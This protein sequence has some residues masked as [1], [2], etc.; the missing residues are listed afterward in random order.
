M[1]RSPRARAS[2][3]LYHVTARG[4]G[5]QLL[6]EDDADR[7]RFMELLR[8]A[9]A[10]HGIALLAW[11]LMGNHVHLLLEDPEFELSK[12]MQKLLSSYARYYNTRTGHVGHVFQERFS[13]EPI[14]EE[15]HL[16]EAVR[17]IHDNPEKAGMCPAREY[18]W[19]S[20]H[21]YLSE[22]PEYVDMTTVSDLIG[23]GRS[24]DWFMSN[25]QE[26]RA[27]S[28]G[29]RVSRAMPDDEL[30]AVARQVLGR[31]SPQDVKMLD[32]ARRNGAIRA[33]LNAGLSIRQ[34]ER[35]TGVGR[36]VIAYVR[37]SGDDF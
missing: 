30:L 14:E 10:S 19:S 34:V 18:P 20:Y 29:V 8:D 12:A 15:S 13:S 33:L 25:Y 37:Q 9:L 24:F 6:F 32:K 36:G 35:I 2:T 5:R 22:T 16:I 3:D 23:T 17:Y 27:R 7:R 21:E 28:A 26:P 1:P 31:T 4:S 11:C